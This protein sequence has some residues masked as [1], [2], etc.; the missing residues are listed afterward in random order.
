MDVTSVSLC[1]EW[2]KKIWVIY[3]VEYYTAIKKKERMPFAVS[4]MDLGIITLSE[5]RPRDK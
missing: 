3:A 2:V 5:V 4:W 1:R